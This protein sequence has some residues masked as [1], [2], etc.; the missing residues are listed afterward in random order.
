MTLTIEL[1]HE[2]EA[3]LRSYADRLNMTIEEAV[4][5]MTEFA[6]PTG[7]YGHLQDGDPKEWLRQFEEWVDSHGQNTVVLPDEAMSRE[8]IYPDRA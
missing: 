5:Q 6:V 3:Q 1:S 4:V 7:S 2:R 8:N